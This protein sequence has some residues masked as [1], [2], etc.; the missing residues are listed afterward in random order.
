MR[1]AQMLV[2]KGAKL[3]YRDKDGD[4]P[5]HIAIVKKY[6]SIAEMLIE[7]GAAMSY[8]NNEGFSPFHWAVFY[9]KF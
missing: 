8:K 5:L 2:E 6:G 3:D 4:T 1:F 7:K 9:G